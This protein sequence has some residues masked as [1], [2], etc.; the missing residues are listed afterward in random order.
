MGERS[1]QWNIH[2]KSLWKDPP[3]GE[4]SVQSK[5]HPKSIWTDLPA[6]RGS[7]QWNI[8]PKTLWKDPPRGPTPREMGQSAGRAIATV[9]LINACC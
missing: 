2:P 5:F 1:V 9:K 7:I 6:D 8:H 4:G 3:M